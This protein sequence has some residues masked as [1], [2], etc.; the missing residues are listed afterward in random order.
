MAVEK[1][2]GTSKPSRRQ[3]V[4]AG[5]GA[6][7]AGVAATSWANKLLADDVRS[8]SKRRE[9]LIKPGDTILFQ[10]DSITDA[11]RKRGISKPNSDAALGHGYAW[12]AAAQLL[13]NMPNADF[14]IFNRGISGNKVYQ[15]AERWQADCL[16][17]K[18]DV[19]SIL[20]GVNDFWHTLDGTYKGTLETYEKDYRA[21]VKRT[22]EALPNVKLVICEP[23]VLKAGKVGE[24]WFPAYDGYRAAAKRV[25]QESGAV[26]VPFQRMFDAATKIAPADSWAKDGVHPTPD[27]AAIMAGAWLSAVGT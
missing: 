14:K 11:G 8:A 19:L 1:H 24:Q 10:G 3:F 20:I 22:K 27:G 7:A 15:L 23:F 26:F 17:L 18:P 12:L 5:I 6:G 16:D 4:Y 2:T 21:L 25:A 13:I 9:T